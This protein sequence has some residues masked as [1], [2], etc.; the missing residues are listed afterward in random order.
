ML[1]R[2]LRV[3]SEPYIGKT[4]SLQPEKGEL[5][6]ESLTI[7]DTA[8]TIFFFGGPLRK[9]SPRIEEQ[10]THCG[11]LTRDN[12]AVLGF[13]EI[14]RCSKLMIKSYFGISNSL[15]SSRISSYWDATRALTDSWDKLKI[16][17]L[18]SRVD[19]STYRI[20]VW[21]NF[22]FMNL[23][24]LISCQHKEIRIRIANFVKKISLIIAFG[25]ESWIQTLR[26]WTMFIRGTKSSSPEPE[27]SLFS[28]GN[29]VLP[30]WMSL[31]ASI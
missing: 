2:H 11:I 24:N 21:R 6:N 18:D 26:S 23:L 15:D 9:L 25:I 1:W 22:G 17:S 16:H 29:V 19:G 4:K 5:V 8:V 7:W 27:G 10:E 20:S 14:V 12:L 30:S 13:L 31:W 28:G 3:S